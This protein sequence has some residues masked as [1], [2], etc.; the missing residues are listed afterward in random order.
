MNPA[1]F[2]EILRGRRYAAGTSYRLAV[3]SR[4]LAAT[5]G[6]YGLASLA[7]IVAALLL[8]ALGVNLPQALLATTMA[9]FLLYAAIV[10][11]VFHARS[12]G[13]AWAWLVGAALPLGLLVLLFSERGT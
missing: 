6:G 9:S 10:M 12:A 1:S 8:G 4:I 3:A 7:N 11:A 13:R 2:R 5:V